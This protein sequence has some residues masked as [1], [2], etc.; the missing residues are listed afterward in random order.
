[1]AEDQDW[2]L[3]ADLADPAGFHERLRGARHF[4]HEMEPLVSQDVVL[5]YDDDSLFGYANT[6]QAIMAARVAIEHQLARDGL[7]AT[8]VVSHWDAA[9]GE[10]GDWH[11]VDPPLD[12]DGLERETREREE[13]TADEV[14]DERVETRTVAITS[15]RMVRNW[16]E[17]TVADEAREAGVEL[18][19]VEHPHLLTTQ[20]AFTLTGPTAKVDGVIE[21]LRNRAG[22]ATRLETA[23]LTPL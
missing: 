19:I 22:Q 6:Q 2:R 1:M 13:R 18:S 3:R 14:R 17:T 7:S 16:F 23:Y 20:I 9:L 5:S 4:E 11:Q 8:L 15:G 10:F 12:E 21:D